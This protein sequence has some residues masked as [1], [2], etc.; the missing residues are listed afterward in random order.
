[1][2]HGSQI[3][4]ED[5]AASAEHLI[6]TMQCIA[7]IHAYIPTYLPTNMHAEYSTYLIPSESF[8]GHRGHDL[9]GLTL[10]APEGAAR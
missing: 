9:K 10:D 7:N 4:I 5:F 1:M 3:P 2:K 8:Q 6:W